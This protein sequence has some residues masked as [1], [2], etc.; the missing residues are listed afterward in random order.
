M[1]KEKPLQR[2]N[3]LQGV[4]EAKCMV[5]IIGVVEVDHNRTCFE[6]GV[7]WGL[8]IIDDNGDTP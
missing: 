4:R 7:R 5:F 8:V 3:M 1:P 2:L 6:D